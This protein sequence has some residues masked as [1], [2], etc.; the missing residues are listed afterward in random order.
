MYTYKYPHFAITVDN[1]IFNFEDPEDIKVMLITRKNEPYK[2]CYALPGGFF[3]P[4]DENTEGAAIRELREETGIDMAFMHE[5]CVLSDKDRDP[6]ERCISIVYSNF[7]DSEENMNMKAGDDAAT[8]QWV[9]LKDLNKDN[10]AF[11]HLKAIIKAGDFELKKFD[12]RS[13]IEWD[14]TIWYYFN[15][16]LCLLKVKTLDE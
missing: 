12:R 11:D 2:G 8:V 13:S 14:R 3:D 10:L 7:V 16:H 15:S 1:V 4:E 5:V 6:R 9:S